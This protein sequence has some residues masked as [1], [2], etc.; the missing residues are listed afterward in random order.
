MGIKRRSALSSNEISVIL[1]YLAS[2]DTFTRLMYVRSQVV[3][4]QSVKVSVVW[5]VAVCGLVE[6]DRFPR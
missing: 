6:I 3:T 4:A 1:R 2:G 5:D